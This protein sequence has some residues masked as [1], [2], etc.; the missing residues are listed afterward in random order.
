VV[1]TLCCY[2]TRPRLTRKEHVVVLVKLAQR[3]D[4]DAQEGADQGSIGLVQVGQGLRAP[5][6][7][8]VQPKW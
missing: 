4:V 1:A 2:T 3:G 7:G 8:S 5:M 6:E